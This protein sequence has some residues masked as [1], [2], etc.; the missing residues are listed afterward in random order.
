MLTVIFAT[1]VTVNMAMTPTAIAC[2]CAGLTDEQA[3]EQA[4][5]VFVG[6]LRQIREPTVK[7]SSAANSRFIFAVDQV[8]KGAVHATQSVVSA[9]DGASCGLGMAP[10][11]IAI[12]FGRGP[13]DGEYSA[14]GCDGSRQFGRTERAGA[15]G[16]A[17]KP[18]PGSSTIGEDN[19][20]P[21][22][23]VRNWYWP[24]GL[25]G[26]AAAVTVW[27]N[28]RRRAFAETVLSTQQK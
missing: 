7:L 17:A 18:L 28:R 21:S 11:T 9:S 3:F 24:V 8:F 25:V 15:F 6:E 14:G 27:R 16:P 22:L 26:L 12:I 19:S 1:T 20:L 23:V 4:D 13:D 2:S 5:A 10:G